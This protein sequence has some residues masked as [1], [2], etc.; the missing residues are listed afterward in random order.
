MVIRGGMLEL[1]AKTFLIYCRTLT[2]Y[3][4]MNLVTKLNSFL[5]LC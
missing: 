5:M 4:G 2:S 1:T 3:S